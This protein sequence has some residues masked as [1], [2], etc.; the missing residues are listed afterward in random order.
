MVN[1]NKFQGTLL[2]KIEAACPRDYEIL[3][4]QVMKM[5]L[6]AKIN[7]YSRLTREALSERLGFTE[8][9]T[10]QFC[11]QLLEKLRR[12]TSN[13]FEQIELRRK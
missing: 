12:H 8:E 9:E 10:M 4:T 1:Q 2:R 11:D 5:L 7:L 13:V 6:G 3:K